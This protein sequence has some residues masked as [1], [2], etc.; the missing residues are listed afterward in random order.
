M[1]ERVAMSNFSEMAD[2]LAVE[3]LSEAAETFF[4]QRKELES[5]IEIFQQKVNVLDGI[6][7]R[8]LQAQKC[9]HALLLN[10]QVM[11]SFY[12]TFGLQPPDR[13][14]AAEVHELVSLV[15]GAFAFTLR[16]RYFKLL[17]R[18]YTCMYTTGKEYLHGGHRDDPADS[19]RKIAIFGYQKLK[20]WSRR[21]NERIAVLNTEQAPSEVLQFVRGLDVQDCEKEK[22]IG[23]SCEVDRDRGLLFPLM[24]FSSCGLPVI[25]ELPPPGDVRR[26]LRSFSRT[27]VSSRRDQIRA[28]FREI[29]ACRKGLGT[30]AEGG[31]PSAGLGADKR[32]MSASKG[33]PR[34]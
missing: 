4:G 24:D 13:L 30:P 31:R 15:P 29:A 16:G 22:C 19:R 6:G 11:Q 10:E 28:L 26:G 1:E 8:F 7:R 14:D 34:P 27:V 2:D 3:V 5:E 20:E 21:I 18:V 32:G 12:Q 25:T 17:L 23:A 9:M 33:G